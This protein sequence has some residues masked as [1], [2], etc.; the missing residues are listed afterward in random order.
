MH[1]YFSI[2]GS[3]CCRCS[4]LAQLVA[5]MADATMAD[6]PT[7]AD[8]EPV[9][10]GA[11]WLFLCPWMYAV[12]NGKFKVMSQEE[13]DELNSFMSQPIS[14][15]SVHYTW[16]KVRYSKTGFNNIVNQ[17]RLD[18]YKEDH[19][20]YGT[21]GSVRKLIKFVPEVQHGVSVSE[22]TSYPPPGAAG[23]HDAADAAYFR[24]HQRRENRC[25]QVYLVGMQLAIPQECVVQVY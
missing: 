23:R 20:K 7:F 19:P 9:I 3:C 13:N 11:D 10:I 22:C 5:R 18:P 4:R 24:F 21:P 6:A 17:Q 2:Q 12:A 1:A 15:Q 14:E 16:G 8:A 25:V